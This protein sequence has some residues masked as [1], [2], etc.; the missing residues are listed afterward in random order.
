M[1]RRSRFS[2]RPNVGGPGRPLAPSQEAAPV[3]Q[4]TKDAQK[5]VDENAAT[6]A[7]RVEVPVAKAATPS[8]GN[9]PSRDATGSSAAVQRRK[10]FSVKPRVAPGPLATLPRTPKPPA[11]V[12]SQS[13]PKIADTQTQA[14]PLEVR[15]PTSPEPDPVVTACDSLESAAATSVDH[16]PKGNKKIEKLSSDDGLTKIPPRPPDKA[17]P[18]DKEA[19]ALSEK[20]K[21]LL[22][23]KSRK[24]PSIPRFSLSRLLNDPSDIQRLEK[25][26]KLRE[27]LRQEMRKEKGAKRA[28]RKHVKEY[29][30]D[31]SKMI[32]RDLIHYLPLS[33]PM[34]SSVEDDTQENENVVP[35]TQ[36]REKSPERAQK[37]D[38]EVP[39]EQ[40]E[41]AEE[42]GEDEEGLM[43]PRVK[44]AEDG[45][46]ILDEESLTVEVQRAKGP[47]PAEDRDPIFE[48]GSTTTYSSFRP[49]TYCKPWTSEETDMFFLAI[50]MVG[51]DFSMIGQ[52]FHNRTRA[53]IRN[54]FKREERQNSWRIDKAFRERRKL[55]I[56]Y[57]SKLLE[58]I[59]E[60]QA[61]RKKLKSLVEKNG[62]KKR[63]KRSKVTKR[64]AFEDE[65]IEEEEEEEDDGEIDGFCS[66]EAEDGEKEN[67]DFAKDGKALGSKN[68]K[69]RKRQSAEDVS[70]AELN[71]LKTKAG[72]MS[73]EE[74][75]ACIPE[76]TEAV[77]SEDQPDSQV[78]ESA[79][80]DDSS[81]NASIKPAKLSRGRAAKPVLPLGRKW[82]KKLQLPPPLGNAE[83]DASAKDDDG[84]T[85][86]DSNE[87]MDKETSSPTRGAS[88]EEEEVD[89]DDGGVSS[90]DEFAAKPAK[91]TRSGRVPKP[92]SHLNYPSKEEKPT[93]APEPKCASKRA[94]SAKAPSAALTS[95]K[96]KLITLRASQSESSDEEVE[97][98]EQEPRRDDE[99][100]FVPASLRSPLVVIPQVDE[101]IENVID[102]LSFEHNEV[103]EMDS[104]NEA[105]QML[106][107]IGNGFDLSQSDT[108][109]DQRTDIALESVDETNKH[110][111]EDIVAEFI[112]E[113]SFSPILSVPLDHRVTQR[114]ETSPSV[115]TETESSPQQSLSVPVSTP[116]VQSSPQSRSGHSS[117]VKPKPNL[118]K[119][120]RITHSKSQTETSTVVSA[121][122]CL[123]PLLSKE[124][125]PTVGKGD[126]LSENLTCD[127]TKANFD[128]SME[129]PATEAKST[130]AESI[131]GTASDVAVT[132]PQGDQSNIPLVKK[133]RDHDTVSEEV[134]ECQKSVA[135]QETR[136]RFLKVKPKP[137]ISQ[138]SG[139]A[140]SKLQSTKQTAEAQLQPDSLETPDQS[141]SSSVS[142]TINIG[143]SVILSEELN[144]SVE[145]K[146][147]GAGHAD[148]ETKPTDSKIIET[149]CNYETTSNTEPTET[150]AKESKGPVDQECGAHDSNLQDLP[151]C[152]TPSKVISTHQTR[153]SQF[154]KAKPKPNL[155]QVSKNARSKPQTTKEIS[156]SPN[157]EATCK[158][159]AELQPQP[160]GTLLELPSESTQCNLLRNQESTC[161]TI[162]ELEPQAACVPIT[163]LTS[164]ELP[165]N[166]TGS[167][168]AVTPIINLGSSM[169]PTKELT[170]SEQKI[171]S[172]ALAAGD[173]ES[174]DSK[175]IGSACI[176]GASS[177]EAPAQSTIP[178]STMTPIMNLSAT[179]IPSEE[180]PSSEE[181]NE[182]VEH[183]T[184]DTKSTHADAVESGQNNETVS[185][186]QVQESMTPLVQEGGDHGTAME[187]ESE[188]EKPREMLP[189]QQ[190]RRRFTRIK[191]K[192]LQMSRNGQSR[193]QPT[194]EINQSEVGSQPTCTL[195]PGNSAQSATSSYNV[196]SVMD[197]SSCVMPLKE[198]NSGENNMGA[199]GL[200]TEEKT[201]TDAETVKSG[202]DNETAKVTEP[203][204]Q[205]P[206]KALDQECGGDNTAVPEYKKLS[207]VVSTDQTRRS[208]FPKIKPKPN[209]C[210]SRTARAKPHNAKEISLSPKPESTCKMT[211]E[212]QP[213][214]TGTSL[215]L[216]SQ[217][218]SSASAMTPIINLGSSMIPTEE[219]TPREQKIT[220]IGLAAGDAESKYSETIGSACKNEASS[221]SLVAELQAEDSNTFLD[222]E[223]GDNDSTLQEL[224][225]SQK[226]SEIV[227]C[228]QTRSG[229]SEVKP[230]PNLLC[231]SSSAQAKPRITKEMIPSPN[232]ESTCKTTAEVQSQS[233]GTF[234]LELP[235]QSTG[236]VTSVMPIMDLGTSTVPSEERT[237][238]AQTMAGVG[239]AACEQ[240]STESETVESD[241]KKEAASDGTVNKTNVEESNKP[242]DH[243]SGAHNSTV[244]ELPECLNPSKV[245]FRR[246][247]FPKVKPNLP[248]IS[249]GSLSKS[250]NTKETTPPSDPG[251][252]CKPTPEVKS[253]ATCSFS[254]QKQE[255]SS[256]PVTPIIELKS[257]F[258]PSEE[259]SSEE[260]VGSTARDLKSTI[261][262]AVES[263]SG[264]EALPQSTSETFQNVPSS[265]GNRDQ[266]DSEASKHSQGKIQR[267]RHL[268][269]IK[270]N[271]RTPARETGSMLASNDVLDKPSDLK[272]DRQIVSTRSEVRPPC[273]SNEVVSVEMSMSTIPQGQSS[274]TPTVGQ[275]TTS[276]VGPRQETVTTTGALN[277]TPDASF[278]NIPLPDSVSPLTCSTENTSLLKTSTMRQSSLVKPNPNLGRRTPPSR[279]KPL[280]AGSDA[281]DTSG[282]QE[283][284]TVLHTPEEGA[285][286]QANYA[287]PTP[288]SETEL[289]ECNIQ[290]ES[291]SASTGFDQTSA[292]LSIFPDTLEVP[293]DPD[294]PFFTLSLVEVPLD[295]APPEVPQAGL[296]ARQSLPVASEVAG[297]GGSQPGVLCEEMGAATSAFV[298]HPVLPPPPA[299]SKDTA[300]AA[301]T[302]SPKRKPKGFL[303]FLSGTKS[304]PQSNESRRGKA[305]PC[306]PN[307]SK[308]MPRKRPTPPTA[309]PQ[310]SATQMTEEHK[311]LMPCTTASQ[312]PPSPSLPA[313]EVS[314]CRDD[315]SVAVLE[316]PT[317]VSQYF[318]SDIF[319]EVEDT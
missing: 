245:V 166:S 20:A 71:K 35:F 205:E 199:I 85:N 111:V 191:P 192:L 118:A 94:R 193:P 268:P 228:H 161:K 248:Q 271:L 257:T 7:R 200:A 176:N 274:R 84:V 73:D 56:E 186:P 76:D 209:L 230:K 158:N 215:E 110:L 57:F 142:P 187:E 278:L 31:P 267:R 49:S 150:Q 304:A 11:E 59:L 296:T 52:L 196:T 44:V 312:P 132:E 140:Q 269:K 316:E 237:P 68:K 60:L 34:L 289:Q 276:N 4:E 189:L 127:F 255:V 108:I 172:I 297:T 260:M 233:S 270:P 311:P 100:A 3:S 298:E 88:E 190:T 256:S 302:V 314:V 239:L 281:V 5:D 101:T 241:C 213:E 309:S 64:K 93:S 47:N 155:S 181:K 211:A 33:N 290:N 102:Y 173:T 226:P 212:L 305:A 208:R 317:N 206:K 138:L 115:P 136:S 74:D 292:S 310:V 122:A 58:K 266:E 27:L 81:K 42:D 148:R 104:Y 301:V 168:S 25:A 283:Q 273:G 319:T 220:S 112:E 22:S 72:E 128:L 63:Q 53:E 254:I 29:S 152:P 236:C 219:L 242:L 246:S 21:T 124:T 107:A 253:Q 227:S 14:A 125:A 157:P 41:A 40:E 80:T 48:R 177:L 162:A 9:D 272:S 179:V 170:P 174:T 214:P 201:S 306:R 154:P 43:V 75:N 183:T 144:S 293:S 280:K 159:T 153:S 92:P 77:F 135:V 24:S 225:K 284:T 91:P 197:L 291:A 221:E 223:G 61:N 67:D 82:G 95:K 287:C 251:S 216:P 307:V 55:D 275:E 10:R 103:S 218:A 286:D 204:A 86:E 163:D 299:G 51:T 313:T 169:I 96:P 114:N 139:S 6:D 282:P 116:T 294:E 89:D 37:P 164:L 263:G 50:S 250:Q 28:K 277:S 109:H 147:V 188:C 46:L 244:Q 117:K 83:D 165:S 121:L 123:S 137:N 178:A 261:G 194:K 258:T 36:R 252:T 149:V 105:A 17:V 119:T 70:N 285:D 279:Q 143:S 175:T 303:S 15:S 249:R 99:E 69:K 131:P 222:Q 19:A 295:A 79:G 247:R 184:Q 134:L 30:L 8:D 224:P 156:L 180:L 167:A 182:T 120:S 39:E 133:S 238:S 66:S 231:T 240:L 130:N 38:P 262:K 259:I 243:E 62:S 78:C 264:Q 315:N 90:G 146:E 288:A 106:L 145:N 229:F 12:G 54:K 171:P 98:E 87:Q 97:V 202:C 210:T 26:Q 45:T 203:E 16:S 308:P 18:L 32:M 265:S 232:L 234:S 160:T 185:N 1:F 13:P 151:E 217:S 195:S 318:L 235:S 300:K 141:S 198:Q 126:Q 207:E 23:S 65:D 2:A 129:P 113:N